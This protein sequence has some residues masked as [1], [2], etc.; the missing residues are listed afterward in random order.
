MKNKTNKCE[1][2]N[3]C[4]V[5]CKGTDDKIECCECYRLHEHIEM[6]V[7]AINSCTRKF[8]YDAAPALHDA[9]DKHF[10]FVYGKSINSILDEI[11]EV[12]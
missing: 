7:D 4:Q 1:Y 11:D 2:Y 10:E 5:D 12:E 8:N 3:R 9:M 6:L